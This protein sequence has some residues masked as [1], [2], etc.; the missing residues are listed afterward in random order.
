TG[1]A[2]YQPYG[3][4]E[5]PTGNDTQKFATYTR[6]SATGLDY[7]Q[8]RYYASQIGR[9]TTAD[10][11]RASGGP[12]DPGSWNRYAYV[13]NDPINHRDPSGLL[14]VYQWQGGGDDDSDGGCTVGWACP[15]DDVG[16]DDGEFVCSA[17]QSTGSFWSGEPDP[18]PC[19]VTRKP[20]KRRPPRCPPLYQNWINAHG[21]DAATVAGQIGTSEA[22]ILA[23]SAY[24]SGWGG[25]SFVINGGDAY[26]NLESSKPAQNSPNPATF[27]Y[28][29]GWRTASQPTTLPNGKQVWAIVA[30]YASYLDSAESFA[31][32]KGSLFKGVTDPFTFGTIAHAN[33]FGIDPGTFTS[34]ADVF[35][36][37]LR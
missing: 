15:G 14:P 7:A 36:R 13:G 18:T 33:G 1:A 20:K 8:N 27:V 25:G 31:Y 6:D 17:N 3:E 24:E 2:Y 28:S 12:A 26:F 16:L 9:F 30:Q 10:P 37:C 5:T 19:A 23:L 35:V 29:T 34:I 11:Y 22:D 21:A 32:Y 4:E